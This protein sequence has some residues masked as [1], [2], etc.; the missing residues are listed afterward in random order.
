MKPG[1]LPLML[2]R[3][4]YAVVA[5]L[6]PKFPTSKSVTKIGATSA[7]WA[8]VDLSSGSIAKV[9]SAIDGCSVGVPT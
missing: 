9:G 6:A 8:D 4:N 7:S 5:F 3:W 2:L 1:L